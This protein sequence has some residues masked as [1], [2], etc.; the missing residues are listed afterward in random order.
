MYRTP[1]PNHQASQGTG[2]SLRVNILSQFEKIPST[3]PAGRKHAHRSV[4]PTGDSPGA[5]AP[6]VVCGVGSLSRIGSKNPHTPAQH[7]GGS[8]RRSGQ[9]SHVRGKE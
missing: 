8:P 6:S 3:N 9:V 4:Q 5:D 7:G 2:P 1:H